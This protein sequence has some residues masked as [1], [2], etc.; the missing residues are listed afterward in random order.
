MQH[1]ELAAGT[2]QRFSHTETAEGPREAIW[3][4]WT[5]PSTWENW[6]DGLKTASVNGKFAQGATGTITPLKGPD[7]SFE[8]VSLEQG[9]RYEFVTKMP[10]ARLHVHRELLDGERTTFRHTVWFS[11]AMAWLWSR[12]YGK[13]FRSALPPTMHKLAQQSL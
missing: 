3:Q 7:A 5:D 10:G 13:Q 2:N 8:V 12:L 1:D 6:D 9:V 4:L 11:G